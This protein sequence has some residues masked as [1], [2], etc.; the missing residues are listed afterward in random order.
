M[1]IASQGLREGLFYERF[2]SA[3]SQPIFADVRRSSVLNLAH[4]YRFQE[5]HAE[6]QPRPHAED[7]ADDGGVEEA[8]HDPQL[9]DGVSDGT[10]RW[11]ARPD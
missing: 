7:R 2:L 10:D 1:T 8:P 11:P 9:T 6:H 4:L 5:Q 3:S